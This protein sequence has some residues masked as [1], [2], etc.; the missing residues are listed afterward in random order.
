M[1]IA[2]LDPSLHPTPPVPATA[3]SLLHFPEIRS[4]FLEQPHDVIVCLPPG[5]HE[6]PHRRY[7][8]LYLHDGQNV[9]DDLPLSPFGVQWGVDTTA[10]AL[11]H[12]RVIEPLIIVAVGN[13]GR[14]R[15][16]EFTPT[17][18][19]MH[20]AGGLADRYG[21]M[22]VYEIKP[23][24][25]H[26]WRTR[27][28]ARDTAVAGSSLGGLLSLHLGLTHPAIFGKVGLLSPSVWWD[29]RWIVR[30][31]AAGGRRP[32]L[33]IWLDVGTGEARMLKGTRLLY[34][35]LLRKGWR[36]GTDLHYME[37]EGALHDERAWG[38]RAGLFLRFLFPAHP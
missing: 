14:D 27:R 23:W 28:T 36:I 21:Q 8:V 2:G 12:A 35:M 29:D 10:R 9:F 31:L 37:A 3:G 17:R 15:I 33:R 38:E 19:N 7:P 24:V 18:D 1:L 32:D 26:S 34:R 11:V 20:D 16:D 5:Y 6:Q 30:Q 25:D 13:A 4:R 22:L